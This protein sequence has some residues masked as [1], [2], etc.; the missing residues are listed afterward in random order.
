[1]Y[2]TQYYCTT[3]YTIAMATLPYIAK[4]WLQKKE[5]VIA[6]IYIFVLVITVHPTLDADVEAAAFPKDAI[7]ED[8]DL[9]DWASIFRKRG[10]A[11]APIF[12]PQL[13]I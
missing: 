2:V 1:M 13:R 9:E 11:P 10:D 8:D 7:E 4:T 3:V 12:Q 6:V 5:F